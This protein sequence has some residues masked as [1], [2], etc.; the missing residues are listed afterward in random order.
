MFGNNTTVGELSLGNVSQD[1]PMAM[2]MAKAMMAESR[3]NY[4]CTLHGKFFI[5]TLCAGPLCILGLAGN[6]LSFLVLRKD[7]ES[8]VA[9]FLLQSLSMTDNF[10]LAFWFLHFSLSDMFYHLRMPFC[11]EPAWVYV[12][13][14][15]DPLM[16]VGQTAMIW[17]TVLIAV[18]RYIAVCVPYKASAL[19]NVPRMKLGASLVLLASLLY[20]IPR[21]FELQ[22]IRTEANGNVHYSFNQTSLPSNPVYRLVYFD[23]LYYISTFVLPLVLLAF[24]NTRLVLAY[25]LIQRKRRALRVRS[26]QDGQDNNITLV[27]IIVIVVFMICNAPARIF[28]IVQKYDQN[29]KCWSTAFIIGEVCSILEVLNSSANFIVYCVFRKQF[30]HIL[31]QTLCGCSR[32]QRSLHPDPAKR[33]LN[34][35]YK[36]N[37]ME[38][39]AETEI[40]L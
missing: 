33:P 8:P 32:A 34:S 1:S 5:N 21:Y 35:S 18:S 22:V 27:M 11:Y 10:F 39:T 24:M 6:T 19:T 16:F 28:Q 13:V 29:I 20:N 31:Q 25:R 26:G 30:R 40:E 7:R 9:S 17:M 3:R 15:T 14:Y 37:N 4:I 38:P 36:A 12:R 23:I 2:D